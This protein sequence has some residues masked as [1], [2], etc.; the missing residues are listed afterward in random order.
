ML[1][2]IKSV[3][4]LCDYKLKILFS[5]GKTKVIDFASW[6]REKSEYLL[7]LCDIRYFKKVQMDEFNYTICW[8]NGADFCPDVLYEVGEDFHN[9]TTQKKTFEKRFLR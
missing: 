3:E 7:P 1:I 5:D 9:K 2:R 8:P 6:L 4:Y